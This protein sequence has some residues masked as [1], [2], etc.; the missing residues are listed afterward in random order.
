MPYLPRDRYGLIG[1]TIQGVN[2]KRRK[3]VVNPRKAKKA[4][5]EKRAEN[6]R[7]DAEERKKVVRKGK[8]VTTLAVRE[9]EP[10]E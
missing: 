4:E 7:A 1:R 10:V 3:N 9:V 2:Q 6:P 8:V 5:R